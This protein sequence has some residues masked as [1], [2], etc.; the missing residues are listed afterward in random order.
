MIKKIPIIFIS[1]VLLFLCQIIPADQENTGNNHFGG[2][3]LWYGVDPYRTNETAL[4]S[5]S[6]SF[7]E[8]DI[9]GQN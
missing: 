6:T 7:S 8:L 9:L 3:F 5:F 2:N 1:I 4:N